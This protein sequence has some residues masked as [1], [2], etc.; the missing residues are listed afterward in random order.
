MSARR[1]VA[2][3]PLPITSNRS[4]GRPAPDSSLNQQLT[5]FADSG[6]QHRSGLELQGMLRSNPWT[7]DAGNQSRPVALQSPWLSI[8]IP[9]YNVAPWLH[10]CVDSVL[11]QAVAGVEII[12]LDDGSSDESRRLC[13]ELHAR[14]RTLRVL[15]HTGNRG[16]GAARNTLLEASTGRYLWFLDGDDT[17][18]PGSIAALHEII[19]RHGPDVVLCDYRKQQRRLAG[20]AGS[21]R[22]LVR[23]REVL[24]HGLFASRHMQVWT[25]IARR[26]LWAADLR[27]PRDSLFEDVATMPWLFLRAG[28]F[29]YCPEAWVDYRVRTG[30]IMARV[31]RTPGHFDASGNLD[32]AVALTGFVPAANVALPGM[33]TRTAYCMS[34]FCAKEFTKIGWRLLR[35]RLLRDPWH[36][37]A[38]RLRQYR[39]LLEDC[40]PMP[41]SR[42]PGQHL[43][44]GRLV[45][46]LR[47]GFFQLAAGRDPRAALSRLQTGAESSS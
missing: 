1:P 23:D 15:A 33:S 46:W 20:F 17:L 7:P 31:S 8:L 4:D 26:D 12:L 22:R 16:L 3:R 19:S 24:L 44:R 43:R 14:N 40:S 5:R 36:T 28:S 9:V 47:L 29:Y 30:S 25:K 11:Q 42:L 13:E 38:A 21:R 35:A 2:Q 41:F 32:L 45:E 39:R 10:Q 34:R 18:L 37:I 27:F 6:T